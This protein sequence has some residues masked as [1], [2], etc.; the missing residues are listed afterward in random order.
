MY[1][2]DKK[3]IRNREIKMEIDKEKGYQISFGLWGHY[4]VYGKDLVV[5]KDFVTMI[6]S[7]K[8]DPVFIRSQVD[9]K[10]AFIVGE[11][12]LSFPISAISTFRTIPKGKVPCWTKLSKEKAKK[13][14]E[15]YKRMLKFHKCKPTIKRWF[16][17]KLGIG[18]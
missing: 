8:Y 5:D 7:K 16:K 1:S 15:R 12:E 9:P 10:G 18:K 11:K 6:E 17:R 4:F 14:M 13:I 2:N 3:K